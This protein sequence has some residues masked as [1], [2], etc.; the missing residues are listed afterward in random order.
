LLDH[1]RFLIYILLTEKKRPQAYG[2]I[3]KD[4][5]GII[6]RAYI[7]SKVKNEI[8]VSAGAIGSP[9]ILMLSG[10]GP[11]NHLK[12]HGIHVVLDQP[13]VGQGMADNPMNVLVVPSPLPVEVSLVETVG[14]TKFGSFIEAISGL[15]FGN[16]WSDWLRRIFEFV[17]NQVSIPY[18]HFPLFVFCFYSTILPVSIYYATIIEDPNAVHSLL[19]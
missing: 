9:Q 14:I 8:I 4:A 10:I 15:N 11:A 19:T 6:H 5:L 2:V 1:I 12:A 16:S 3:F 18:A 13:L 17:S 7:S